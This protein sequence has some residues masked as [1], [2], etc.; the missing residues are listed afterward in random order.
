MQAVDEQTAAGAALDVSAEV[1]KHPASDAL[2][3]ASDIINQ[4]VSKRLQA[5]A[6]ALQVEDRHAQFWFSQLV[7]NLH[8]P[9]YLAENIQRIF[10]SVLEQPVSLRECLASASLHGCSLLQKTQDCIS[11][12]GPE[13]PLVQSL[14]SHTGAVQSGKIQQR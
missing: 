8:L 2:I 9:Q 11:K 7:C 5:R 13:G 12:P 4:A 1:S 10:P 3:Q 6:A 14:H